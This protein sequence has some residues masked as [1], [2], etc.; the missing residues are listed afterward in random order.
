MEGR[1][2]CAE[3][4]PSLSWWQ[5]DTILLKSAPSVRD[6]AVRGLCACIALHL[7]L[8]ELGN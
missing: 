2:E 8:F 6:G 3:I 4:K 1:R 7:F 5:S